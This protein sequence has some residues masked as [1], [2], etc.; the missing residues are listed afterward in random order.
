MNAA[1]RGSVLILV[2]GISAMLM[3]MT[4]AFIMQVRT[5]SEDSRLF[6]QEVQARAM[7]TAALQYIQETSRLGWDDP[8]ASGTFV[9]DVEHEDAFGWI[10]VRDG[11]AGPRVRDGRFPTGTGSHDALGNGEY[12]PWAGGK[13]AR[14][15]MYRMARPPFAIKATTV[16]NPIRTDDLGLPWKDMVN[17]TVPDPQPVGSWNEF[18]TADRTPDPATDGR[19][20]FRVY[21]KSITAL[22]PDSPSTYT[23]PAVFVIT[24]G[25]GASHGFRDWAEVVTAGAVDRFGSQAEFEEIRRTETVY[26]FEAEWNPAVDAHRFYH[27]M[28]GWCYLQSQADHVGTPIYNGWYG[29]SHWPGGTFSYIQRLFSEPTNW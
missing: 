21:R 29:Y 18:V 20:W 28:W 26:W 6:T 27:Y 3:S 24:C 22:D 4:F 25:A 8:A 12:F 1:S 14:C 11:K 19:S 10:D 17:Y 2:A 7:L 23:G 16:A 15:P 5:H 9:D 13:A